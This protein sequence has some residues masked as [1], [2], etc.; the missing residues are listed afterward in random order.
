ME[1]ASS[2]VKIEQEKRVHSI[3]INRVSVTRAFTHK[4][5][6]LWGVSLTYEFK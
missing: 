6:D 3:S 2:D 1:E 4:E 5:V